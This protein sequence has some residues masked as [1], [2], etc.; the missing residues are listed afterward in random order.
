MN[1]I[2]KSFAPPP[3]VYFDAS[4]PE[5][6]LDYAEYLKYNNWKGGCKFLLEDPYTD[7]PSMVSAKVIRHTLGEFIAKV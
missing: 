1:Y 2:A 7:I 3:R 4:N 6:L 5:H